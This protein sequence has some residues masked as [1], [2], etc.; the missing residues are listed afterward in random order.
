APSAKSRSTPSTGRP[1][2]ARP[3][4]DRVTVNASSAR[5]A[6]TQATETANVAA[7]ITKASAGDTNSSRPPSP[8]PSITAAAV[9]TER[10]AFAPGRSASGTSRGVTPATDG[11]DG[12]AAL[13]ASAAI[14]GARTTGRC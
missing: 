14:T 4:A 12:A 10:A 5:T 8:G 9:N 11:M 13:V 2:R 7:L 1:M 6:S 3:L